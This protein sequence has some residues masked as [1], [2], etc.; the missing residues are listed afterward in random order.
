M[1]GLLANMFRGIFSLKGKRGRVGAIRPVQKKKA[2][3]HTFSFYCDL[4]KLGNLSLLSVSRTS[5]IFSHLLTYV[6]KS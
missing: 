4:S 2:V 1:L 5:I 3:F 6:I